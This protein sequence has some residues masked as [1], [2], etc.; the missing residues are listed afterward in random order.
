MSLLKMSSGHTITK[1]SRENPEKQ[2][3]N[4][5]TPGPEAAEPAHLSPALA[6]LQPHG[7]SGLRAGERQ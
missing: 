5:R 1:A 2:H 3:T 7:P 6:H 4:I